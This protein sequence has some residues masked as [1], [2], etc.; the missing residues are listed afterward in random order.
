MFS[1]YGGNNDIHTYIV[2]GSTIVAKL[3]VQLIMIKQ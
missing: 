2:N 3:N 1:P